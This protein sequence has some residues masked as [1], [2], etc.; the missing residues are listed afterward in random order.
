MTFNRTAPRLLLVAL[1][2]GAV[3][4]VPAAGPPAA[5]AGPRAR[6]TVQDLGTL[7][8][9]SSFAAD[10]NERGQ[11]VGSSMTA[12]G[13]YRAFLWERGVMQDLGTLGGSESLAAAVNA[14]GQVVGNSSDD[15][16]VMHAFLWERGVMHDLGGPDVGTSSAS[17]VNDRGQVVVEHVTDSGVRAYLWDRGTLT[18]L[19]VMSEAYPELHATDL[20]AGGWVT[21]YGPAG[22][23]GVHQGFLWRDGQLTNLGA[24]T[25]PDGNSYPSALNDAGQVVGTTSVEDGVL[26]AAIWQ[27]GVW[28]PLWD[29]AADSVASDVNAHGTVVGHT[30]VSGFGSRAALYRDGETVDLGALAPRPSLTYA[31]NDRDQV[32]GTVVGTTNVAVLWQEGRMDVL[33]PLTPGGGTFAREINARGLVVGSATAPDG[34]THAVLWSTSR[35]S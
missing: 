13:S 30:Y 29:P 21:G 7:G 23:D 19:G 4:A 34:T 20:N 35:G 24:A 18:D 28:T 11:V 25:G 27:D 10:V 17:L 31:V 26:G 32:I 9:P 1:L 22:P 14:R 3:A 8:G 2:A 33:P 6:T 12:D 5:A 15:D 16:G